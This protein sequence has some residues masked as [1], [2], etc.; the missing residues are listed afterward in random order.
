M[1]NVMIVEDQKMI[2]SILE[3]Y[4]VFHPEEQLFDGKSGKD[5]EPPE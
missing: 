3:E 5:R 4:T 1:K 2:R